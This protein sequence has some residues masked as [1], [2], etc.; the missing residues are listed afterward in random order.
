MTEKYYKYTLSKKGEVLRDGHTMFPEDIIRDLNRKSYLEE[1]RCL[2]YNNPKKD[3]D[4]FIRRKKET[5][6]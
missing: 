2:V 6:K 1:N 4:A 3:C 5:S